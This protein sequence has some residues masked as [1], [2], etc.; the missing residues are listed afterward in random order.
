M[1]VCASVCLC[2]F[3]WVC[4]CVSVCVSGCVC[5]CVSEISEKSGKKQ[6]Y[7]MDLPAR[8][9]CASACVL[10]AL[11]RSSFALFAF[12]FDFTANFAKFAFLCIS[13]A[14]LPHAR[15]CEYAEGARVLRGPCALGMLR[16][17]REVR[18]ACMCTH[19]VSEAFLS[20]LS[21]FN[22]AC[23]PLRHQR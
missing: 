12:C 19:L 11:A 17:L 18:C 10:S 22:L 13:A 15:G 3:V 23:S 1:C 8:N 14:A 20:A 9:F 7:E 16:A 6:G 21:F 5:V 4:A 2:V